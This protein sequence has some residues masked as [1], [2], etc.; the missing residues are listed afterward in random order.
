M[1]FRGIQTV[2]LAALIAV[3]A[4]IGSTSAHADVPAAGDFS[5]AI[6][7]DKAD[8]SPGEHVVLSGTNWQ[9]GETVH[10]TV[11]DDAGST[12]NRSVDVTADDAGNITDEFDLPSWFVAQYSVR[13]EGASGSVAT[14]AF[15]DGNVKFDVNP[16]GTLTTAKETTFTSTNCGTGGGSTTTLNHTGGD[17]VGGVNQNQSVQLEVAATSDQGGSF[18]NWTD[19]SNNVLTT[20][21]IVCVRGA[22]GT[23]TVHA[24]YN[25]PAANSAPAIAS[26]N[27]AVTVG[28]GATAANTGTWS[29]A[30][31]GDTV[32]LS[33][34]VGTVTKSGTN[35]SGTWSWSYNPTD[36]PTN[37]QTVTISAF[38]GTTTTSTT[39]GLTVNNVAPS[40]TAAGN[41]T[42]SEGT[43]KSF[44]LGSFT[45]PG[46]DSPWAVDV[47]WGDGSTHTTFNH[48][49]TGA[50]N[51]AQT[52]A[53]QT[54]TYAD[55][56][57]YTVS[58]KVT[59]KDGGSDTKTFTVTVSNVAPTVTAAANQSANEG[60][61]ASID[62]G[63]F[64]DPGATD[65]PW[66]VDVDWGDGSAHTTFNKAVTG[67]LGSQNHTYADGPN[68][69]TVKVTVTDKNNAA[70]NTAQFTVTVANVAPTV[71]LNAA[72]DQTVNEGS[73]QHIYNYT[74]NDL[75]VDTINAV[76]TSCGDNGNKVTGSDTHTDTTGSFKC[77]FSDGP[78]SSVVSASAT[79]SDG[80]T[81]NLAT[82]S[83]TVNNVAPTVNLT[84]ATTVNEGSTHTYTFTVTD[85]GQDTFTV[86]AGFPDCDAGATNN[87]TLSG[88]PTVNAGGG[89][90][91]CTFPDGLTTA[92]VKVKVTDSDNA[93]TSASESVDV[94]TVAN[95]APAITP[96]ADQS[97]SEGASTSF[98]LGSFT[99]PGP[100]APWNVDVD[101]GDGSA[102]T[103]FSQNTTGSLGSKTH[104]Y[105]D[106]PATRTVSV[107]VTDKNNGADTKTFKV[108]V[109]NVAPTVTLNA[110]NDQTVNEG[111]TVH[112]YT[113]TIFDPGVLDTVSAV[114][115]SCGLNGVKG[116]E[117]HTNTT[118]SFECTFPDGDET[119]VVSASAKD[120]DGGTGNLATQ[121]V[122]IKNVA[123]TVTAPGDQNASEGTGASIGLGSFT[124]PGAN[125]KPWHVR[126][127]WGDGTTDTE[128]DTN[129]Q[130]AVGSKAHTYADNGSYIV[131][132]TVAD[133]DTG[134]GSA[135]FTVTVANAA[136]DVT[137]AAAQSSNEGE[138]KSFSLGSFT[139][140]GTND[141][142]WKVNVDWGDGTSE[143]EFTKTSQGTLGSKSHTYVDNGSYTVSVSVT[144]KDGD[145][146]SSTFTVTV[147]NV[148]PDV[149]AAA[150]QTADEGTSKSFL[151]GVFTDPGTNDNPWKVKVEW[152]DGTSDTTFNADSIGALDPK[153]HTYRDNGTY[154]VTVTVADK[155]LESDSGTFQVTVA[156]VDP[157]VT[158]ADEQFPDEGENHSFAIGSFSDPGANDGA[159]KVKVD[160]GDG[161]NA[162]EF[163]TSS[164]GTLAAQ[165]HTYAN[166]DEYL[167]TVTVTD[168]DGG[169]GSASFLVRVLNV[170]PAVTA[171]ADQT[172]DEGDNHSFSLGSFTDPGADSPW[173]VDV[174]WGD[175]STHT[176]FNTSSPGSLGSQTHK[177]AD[178]PNNYTVTVKVTESGASAESGTATFK[179]KVDNVAPDVTAPA[180]QTANEGTSSSIE[181]GSF[182]DPGP[183]APWSVDVDW[184]DGT[185]APT[186]TTSST[187]SLGSLNHSYGD[188]GTYTVTVTV[189]D[190]NSGS[191]TAS[192]TV[193]VSNV[194][195]VVS[196]AAN[197]TASEGTSASI[198]L[199]SFSDPG[200]N[201]GPW[202]VDVDWG[203]GTA[204]GSASSSAPGDLGSL[205]HTYVDNGEYTVKVTVTDK[206][207]G[208]GHAS[209][210][211]TVANVDPTVTA[212]AD[213]G[214]D[215][216]QAKS[217]GIGS[218]SDRGV[219]D[220]A[221]KVDVDW[222]D[223]H[224]EPQF[225]TSSQG[226]L[227]SKTHTYANNGTYTVT[228][229]V[230]DKDGGSG[231]ASFT[232]TV[233]NVPPKVTAA[234]AQTASEGSS[235]SFAVGS[236]TDPGA[237]DPWTVDVNWG[238]T[239]S[240]TVFAHSAGSLGSLSHTYADNGSYTVT[241]KVTDKDG[242]SDSATF[243]ITVANVDP[244]V[245]AADNQTA[246]EGTQK[247]FDLGSFT[248]PGADTWTVD[249]DWGDG[250]GHGATSSDSAGGLGTLDH[251]YA[252]N[253]SYTVTVKVTDDDGGTGSA[254]F[255][256]TVANV[257]P[258]VT[259]AAN[260]SSNEGETKSFQLGSFTDPGADSWTVDVDWGD[261][262]THGNFNATSVG[263]L[264]AL[265]H[266]YADNGSYTVTVKVT[267][268]DGGSGTAGF[269][270][271]VANVA[272]K[273]TLLDSNDREVDE[274]STH[275]Y[276]FT[277]TDPGADTF[278]RVDG[279]PDCD[280]EGSNGSYV[281]GS[282]A[283]TE[284]G[285]SF[286]CFF[287]DGP[288]SAHVTIKVVDDDGGSGADSES[289]QIVQVANVAPNVTAAADQSSDEGED[290]SFDLGSFTDDG[291]NDGPFHV[292]VD[293]G[294]GSAEQPLADSATKGPLGST[295]HIYVNNGTYTVK[296][297]VTDKDGDSGSSTFKVT[298]KNVPPT[299]TAAANQTANEGASTSFNLGSFDDPGANDNPW[300]VDVDWGDDTP[301]G[302][303]NAPATGSL[304][305]LS[306]TYADNR[307]YTVTVKVTD[308][309]GG[310]DSKTF[311]VK[312]SNVAPTVTA[313]A[314]QVTPE[315]AQTTFSLGSFT[316]PGAGDGPWAVDV[317]WGDGSTHDTF[318]AAST[319]SLISRDHIYADGPADKVVT[320]KVTD[321]D[322]G[323]D[324]KTFN[325]H[326]NDVAPKVDLKGPAS[327]DEGDVKD[328]T[329][330]VTDPG[331]DT[332]TAVNGYPDCD[333]NG[334]N[335]SIVPG[336][337]I[338]STHGGSFQCFFP[339]GPKQAKVTM[340][341]VD[342]DGL[343]ASDSESVQIVEVA[344]VAPAVT[345]PADQ[346]ANEGASTSFNLGSFSDPGT[347]S[348]W[349]VDV[350][351]GD[352]S[353]HNTFDAAS[354]GSLGSLNHTYADNGDYTAKVTVSDGTASDSN[355][356]KVTVSN[357]APTV[358]KPS[359][360]NG[361]EG[362]SKSFGLGSF[363]DPGANDGP[364]HIKV[365]WGD[366]SAEQALADA[367]HTGSLGMAPHAY[368][369]N[370]TYTVTVTV[371]DKDGGSDSK[372]YSVTIAN[373]DPT[374]SL[375]NGGAVNEGSPQTVSF[376]NQQDAPADTTAGF[377]YAFSCD[378]SAFSPA[379]TY[380]SAGTSAS[381]SCP[382]PDSP[383][384]TV[385]ARI[386]DKDG[387][388][389]EYTTSITVNNVAPSVTAAANQASAEGSSKSFDLGS[390][391]DPGA[392]DNPWAV[393]VNWG[394]GS[395]HTTD[396]K[397]TTGS[398]G[399]ASHTY[400]DNGTYTVTVTVKDKDQA[401]DNKTFS[402]TVSNVAPHITSFTGTDYLVG[403]NAYITGGSLR[404]L[405]TTN[406]TDPGM[407]DTFKADFTYQDGSPTN[408][409]L[410]AFT[411]GRQNSHTFAA[412]SV[413]CK[414]ASVKV[415]DKDGGYDTA[416]TIVHVGSGA[417][418]PPMTNQPV[419]DK[420]K[421]GQTL[422][423]K[424]HISDCNGAGATGLAP[425]IRLLTGDI[426][427]QTDDST[428]TITIPNSVS[429]ADTTG[430]MRS[431]GGGDYMYN[432]AVNLPKL[433]QDYT[434]V[435]Y[436]YGT[437][438]SIQLGHVIQATK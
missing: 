80:A 198:A 100:D 400:A 305:S 191:D 201:D 149:T 129:S 380:A 142:P 261:G 336:T 341:V 120:S 150:N 101:W 95:V 227:G 430:I 212:A 280:S 300:A 39:F 423:V 189:T 385:R 139:D 210:K 40:V 119:S 132:I 30:N 41:Q 190:K 107:T 411:S 248:D 200:A 23:V 169:G 194:D 381:T 84:G 247:S 155:D 66:A 233:E 76:T 244:S 64:T 337:Y 124:D 370:G 207:S 274:G 214:S 410:S 179:V 225:P 273:V 329:F 331:Q 349:H 62:L 204:H 7:S 350:D 249:V 197:Q 272:P 90:F 134:T 48:T 13:A 1:Q 136:P 371:T 401:S 239:S 289:V 230:T 319:G 56:G 382:T 328:Y 435:I 402:V 159:W 93:S 117:T 140:A 178:G 75:G 326:V 167:V 241:V 82:Q 43:S 421:N 348:A 390:F 354:T 324:S 369:D 53:A 18:K 417:F 9:A 138:S 156:N 220:G 123:P 357:V 3:A 126:V 321:K 413:G 147:S 103:T 163:N 333:A 6:W 240:E 352:G 434:V 236:F 137:A 45:D 162:T 51:T 99:D 209:F 10:I 313:A 183:D 111:S 250:S 92:N 4:L 28:E 415:T 125:D 216:G 57:T 29:D 49:L 263:G 287:P 404:S 12:W 52:L 414:T 286:Q 372:T 154:T 188:N 61:S 174:D 47:D 258:V 196:A 386:I 177:Y 170:P 17:N 438:S 35:T 362:A 295:S 395:A 253:G 113:Y 24:N 269:T 32:T 187:G 98:N 164:Q 303:F 254:T 74:I 168:K 275:T 399:S 83:I 277:V 16:S 73:T 237:D 11:N 391:N 145:S 432:M 284:H 377:H 299:V 192:F 173:H 363:T 165:N 301:H 19:D 285:G 315:G 106:G 294:D 339:D 323:S 353:T 398:L 203:D 72:N 180:G 346:T 44:T 427:P 322:G 115:T 148:A 69:Y 228:V 327:A 376:S 255:T 375:G 199:G 26:N 176:T 343:G 283:Q 260:Q 42:A 436:P 186:T 96:P 364:W 330:T 405:F 97:A 403:P 276:T 257:D 85:P 89:S 215:E 420:L 231:S 105:A 428:A 279:Y 157:K 396:S 281:D 135:S 131:T 202:A 379:P 55:N 388:F 193:T 296:V 365:N 406:F 122:T 94:V 14:Y 133:K 172:T 91:D 361:V 345:A 166:D 114:D 232:I 151:L 291:A 318:S 171:A 217:F 252:D 182:T 419:T 58:V 424:V 25:A 278:S 143:P 394:D 359:D 218:F 15:T 219:N 153:S 224:S 316:D 223:G 374:A 46:A 251:T 221:W 229:K 213:Q 310:S 416:S 65:N 146:D 389:N 358:S 347:E 118:G 437:S 334:D 54:H 270:I 141:S 409:T 88:T 312:V 418:Q 63:S 271:N 235:S 384:Q 373:A 128:F 267:D 264:G 282:Y 426:T 22:S 266:K 121:T 425:V 195:P 77:T 79:D 246:F 87:G 259:A 408:E 431:Q 211:V 378:G 102:H 304:G 351:W 59:D 37:S 181:L 317:D 130:G 298:V 160:W 309:D 256:V 206:D 36:G 292:K 335:G 429:A 245:T 262:S 27:A 293:W 222:G 344:N 78:A 60:S 144:D 290:H 288:K 152:G 342:E 308:K 340:Q 21:T 407:A 38:D 112:T 302:T 367:T 68:S 412:N 33:A 109:A 306:H 307:T 268:D 104:T 226:T 422:P 332:F 383:S 325:V 71:T 265:S 5:P 356:F 393:D 397:S 175:G 355:M 243:L 31:A 238:D 387:G 34:S 158:A 127:D 314:D 50:A 110:D 366:G 368:A 81:G 297:T 161:S 242:A 205:D 185:S 20:S 67:S 116:N 311:E 338:P 108:N 184:G 320:V 360:D 234:A 8:Y 86:D 70:S 392:H 208:S 2:L 433:N